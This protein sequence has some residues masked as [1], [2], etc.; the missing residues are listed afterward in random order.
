MSFIHELEIVDDRVRLGSGAVERVFGTVRCDGFA[1]LTLQH[2]NR[3][4]NE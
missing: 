1:K 2:S 4:M 3:E